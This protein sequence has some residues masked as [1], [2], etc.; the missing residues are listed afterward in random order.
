MIISV[1][2]L[3]AHSVMLTNTFEERI[4]TTALFPAISYPSSGGDMKYEALT[5]YPM[6][7]APPYTFVLVCHFNVS[8]CL[9][10]IQWGDKLHYI[11]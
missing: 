8:L 2:W 6:L 5:L 9:Y 7:L 3:Q 1:P 11:V 10:Q 4:R